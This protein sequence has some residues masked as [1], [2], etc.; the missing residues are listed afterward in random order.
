MRKRKIL[1]L[2]TT[3]AVATLATPPIPASQVDG[4][5]LFDQER[6]EDDGVW[7]ESYLFP[8]L[9]ETN[10]DEKSPEKETEA[11]T[12]T[13]SR[14]NSETGKWATIYDFADLM[15]RK[16]ENELLDTMV[17]AT[18]VCDVAL[19]TDDGKQGLL[20]TTSSKLAAY[21]SKY[22]PEDGS[23]FLIDMRNREIM[24]ANVG[25][26][27][28]TITSSLS[29]S[30]AD[31]SYRKATDG[32]YAGCARIAF[33]QVI[34]LL[35][36]KGIAQPMKIVCSAL[37]ALVAGLLLNYVLVRNSRERSRKKRAIAGIGI[38]TAITAAAGAETLV[39]TV[40][41]DRSSG[42]GFGRGGGGF[43]GGFGGGGGFSSGGHRF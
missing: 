3:L 21:V 41:R 20:G 7:H 30:I 14:F 1:V 5:K 42:G 23:L 37:L 25:E 22:M 38:A 32:D 28:K 8:F 31:N 10:A 27:K 40:R 13:T 18:D 35:H 39:R 19:V 34:R 15:T 24:L 6:S 33:E 2:A 9:Y 17:K 11:R 43:G 4:S 16:E 12:T 26:N 29:R 36:G